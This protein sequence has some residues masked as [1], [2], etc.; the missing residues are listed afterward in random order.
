MR[1]II[2]ALFLVTFIEAQELKKVSLQLLWKHQFEFAGYYMAKE[3]GFYKEAGLDVELIEYEFG[4]DIAQNVSKRHTDFGVGSSAVILDKINGLD[5][6]LLMPTLQTSPFVLMSKK[7]PDIKTVADLKGKKIMFTPNQVTMASLDAMLTVNHISNRDYIHQAHSFNVQDLIDEKTDAMSAYL[8]NEPY[9]MIEKKIP[10]T[11]FNP[12]DFGFNF[13][14]DILFTS[15]K[16]YQEDPEMVQK[17]Y[18]ATQKGWE[19]AFNHI[20]ESAQVI[21]DKY[22]TQNKSLKHLHFEANEL[23]RISHFGSNE[24]GKFKP[25]ILQ[26]IIQTYN[27]LNISKSTVDIQ[28]MVY[29]DALYVESSIDYI[30]LW[31]IVGG[32]FALFIALYYWNRKLSKLNHEIQSSKKK[33]MVLLDNAGQGFLS[34]STDFKIDEEHSKECLKY[35]G[36]NITHRNITDLLFQDQSKK[37]FFTNTLI[38]ALQEKNVLSQNAILSLLPN[39]ILLNKRALRLEYKI[40]DTDKIM[41]IITNISE[42][43][44]L[45]RKIKK[46]QEILKMIVAVV[47][48][49]DVFYDAKKDFTFFTDQSKTLIDMSKTA[50]HNV[51]I[52][53]RIIHTYKGTFSQLYMI[54]TVNFLHKVENDLSKMI[55]Q[56]IEKN[57]ELITF[58][59]ECDFKTSFHKDLEV[60]REFLGDEFLEKENF[61]QIDIGDIHSLQEKITR[62]FNDQAYTTPECTDVLTYIQS[63]STQKLSTLLKPYVHFTQQLGERLNKELY[64]LEIVGDN[65]I[66][67][68]DTLKPFIKSLIHV[69]RNSIDHGIEEAQTRL[70]KNKD[71]KGSISCSFKRENDTLHLIISDDGAGLDADKIKLKLRDQGLETQLLT[72]AELY[73]HIFDDNFSTKEDI[74]TISGRGIGLGAVK[75]ELEKQG[76]RVEIN[77]KKD[78]GT[79]FEFI[80]PA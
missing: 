21:F 4:T 74:S 54:E 41:M 34:F 79:T 37:E 72:D 62:I 73:L 2:L 27:L 42:Q 16:L 69:F 25:E 39:L 22:N 44:K 49:S 63:L 55:K 78:V 70:E 11:I 9:H 10:Y 60:I 80:L 15:Y 59:E 68:S 58:L 5:V 13:Y 46:E 26:Q 30:L 29:P 28:K 35:L 33:V 48:E 50:L 19:Y 65:D 52:L 14:D 76:G 18:Q 77:S 36:E 20:D 6:Y 47:S 12:S 43:K 71:E 24:Y 51:T 31:K 75:N 17:F 45:E 32:V 56:P 23:K 66:T 3:K 53:Y 40:I 1:Y 38:V 64:D 7:R 8:S 67:V 57:D 61:V